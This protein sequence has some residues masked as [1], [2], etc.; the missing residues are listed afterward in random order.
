MLVKKLRYPSAL[1]PGVGS[2]AS[3]VAHSGTRRRVSRPSGERA[4][5]HARAPCGAR[6]A[7]Q[8]TGR[9][10][11]ARTKQCSAHVFIS[12]AVSASIRKNAGIADRYATFSAIVSGMIESQILLRTQPPPSDQ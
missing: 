11:T 4:A 9:S 5:H 3:V 2:T 8:R 1:F 10:A 12:L 6:I 7:D